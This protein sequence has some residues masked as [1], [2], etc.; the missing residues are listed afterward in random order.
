MLRGAVSPEDRFLSALQSNVKLRGNV[1]HYE[2]QNLSKWY[3]NRKVLGAKFHSSRLVNAIKGSEVFKAAIYECRTRRTTTASQPN[4]VPFRRELGIFD[5]YYLAHG[6][7]DRAIAARDYG[8]DESNVEPSHVLLIIVSDAFE[9]LTHTERLELV[10]EALLDEFSGK[11]E[12]YEGHNSGRFNDFHPLQNM[13]VKL[14]LELHATSKWNANLPK[15][16]GNTNIPTE[17]SLLHP[18][19]RMSHELSTDILRDIIN[20]KRKLSTR[21]SQG[22]LH[23][24]FYNRGRTIIR[25]KLMRSEKAPRCMTVIGNDLE[26]EEIFA[27]HEN[28]LSQISSCAIRMQRMY[29]LKLLPRIELR[30]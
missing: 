19:T 4:L 14:L 15:A 26:E 28:L 27:K 3:R 16:S 18:P 23:S 6:A 21:S 11:R 22:C 29:R 30:W 9:N 2:V 24:F 10:F 20:H 7:C 25:T 8:D 13:K 12:M 17:R 5:S 1:V